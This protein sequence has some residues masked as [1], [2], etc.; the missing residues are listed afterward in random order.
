MRDVR[1]PRQ[2]CQYIAGGHPLKILFDAFQPHSSGAMRT[3]RG[4]LLGVNPKIG[5]RIF[6]AAR[7]GGT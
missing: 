7:E 2:S 3:P 4:A 5:D 1:P 6:P